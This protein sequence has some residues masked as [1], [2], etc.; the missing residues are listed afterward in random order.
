MR[1]F[2]AIFCKSALMLQLG[3]LVEAQTHWPTQANAQAGNPAPQDPSLL[4]HSKTPA[5]RPI[6][7]SIVSAAPLLE[8]RGPA[9]WA[10]AGAWKMAAAPE[11]AE[12]GEQVS[13]AGYRTDKWLAATVPG[14]VLSTYIDRGIYPEP[15][16]GLNN[17][18]IP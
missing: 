2:R 14:T 18:A 15:D 6:A 5:Q 12:R 8:R 4:P 1:R 11:V 13:L 17:L 9:T 16:Y 7:K 3:L 10:I